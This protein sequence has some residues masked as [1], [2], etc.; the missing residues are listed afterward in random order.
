VR[1]RIDRNAANLLEGVGVNLHE[2][3]DVAERHPQRD[4]AS[5]GGTERGGKKQGGSSDGAAH[6]S[7]VTI[8]RLRELP[9]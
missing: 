3:I 7:S 9:P 5:L 1:L 2:L 4:V 8:S 6:R